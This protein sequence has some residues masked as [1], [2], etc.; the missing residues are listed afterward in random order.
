MEFGPVNP[1]TVEPPDELL[2]I[3]NPVSA[4][5]ERAQH[6]IAE[7]HQAHPFRAVDILPTLHDADADPSEN[8]RANQQRIIDELQE[9]ADPNNP[10][11]P[12]RCWLVVATGDGTIRDTAEALLQADDAIRGVPILP[13]AGGN[14]NDVSSMTH[15]F[16]G[17]RRPVA[18]LHQAHIE[19]VQPLECTLQYGDGEI[20]KR[21][22]LGYISIG[23]ITARTAK[24]IDGDRGHSRI[25]QLINEKLLAMRSVAKAQPITVVEQGVEHE[26]FDLIFANGP[27]MAKYLH[28]KQ[29]LYQPQFMRTELPSKS[30]PALAVAGMRLALGRYPSTVVP[31]GDA[32]H[33]RTASDTWIQ[34]DGEAFPLAADTSIS[35]RRTQQS[36]NI[37]HL[38]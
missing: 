33:L 20:Q 24:I 1:V 23:E 2:V 32:V 19:P 16:W 31:D 35:V 12:R 4:N 34:L 27:R 25:V 14:G 7:L 18:Q 38:R 5:S 15:G 29:N 11:D 30:A 6:Q 10:D 36:L 3:R 13:L 21:Y 26:T 8:R 37:V 28:W 17:K 22:A 9:R